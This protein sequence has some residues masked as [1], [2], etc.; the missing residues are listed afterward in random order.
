MKWRRIKVYRAVRK[1]Y[2]KYK[3]ISKQE[4]ISKTGR[5]RMLILVGPSGVGKSTLERMLEERG[6]TRAVSYTT[7]QR[8]EGEENGVHYHFVTRAEMEEMR[9]KGDLLECAEYGGNLYGMHSRYAKDGVVCVV[10]VGG[11]QQILSK[12]DDVRVVYITVDE[13]ERERR[14]LKRG[15]MKIEDIRERIRIDREVFKGVS[16]IS[17]V[18]V[19]DGSGTLDEVMDRIVMGEV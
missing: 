2:R 13:E 6:Y 12:V 11:M 8:R 16:D 18:E 14:M 3:G 4:I 15:G 1:I 5:I 10:E 19:V 9:D 17:R 7:R